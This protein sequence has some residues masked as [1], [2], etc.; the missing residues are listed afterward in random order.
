MNVRA[1]RSRW[2]PI[3]ESFSREHTNHPT[4]IRFHRACSWLQQAE[5][6]QNDDPDMTLTCQWIAFNA[7]YGQWDERACEPMADRVSWR[8]FLGK[9]IT[10][11]RDQVIAAI[12]VEHK[13]LVMSILDDAYLGSYFWRD[14]STWR[15]RNTTRD[16][17]DASMWYVEKR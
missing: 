4:P 15:A 2:K 3:K 12:L 17:R 1:L 9:I 5:A 13:N 14:P 10:L 8:Q 7:L 16:R 11:D 6:M